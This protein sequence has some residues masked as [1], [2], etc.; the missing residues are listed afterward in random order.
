MLREFVLGTISRDLEWD[1]ATRSWVKTKKY[2]DG[3]GVSDLSDIVEENWIRVIDGREVETI[4]ALDCGFA[5]ESVMLIEFT[6]GSYEVG[7]GESLRPYEQLYV[8]RD[9]MAALRAFLEAIEHAA[10][11]FLGEGPAE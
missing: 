5:E 2:A 4:H 1:E 9:G 10:T 6:D 7:R 8:G 11:L 3:S